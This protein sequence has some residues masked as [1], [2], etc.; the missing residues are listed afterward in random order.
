VKASNTGSSDRFG[1]AVALSADGST[2]AVAAPGESSSAR[3][4]GGDEADNS[5][6]LAGAVYVFRRDAMGRWAQEAYLKANNTDAGDDFGR[7]LALSADG[8]RL[9]VGAPSEDSNA[10]FVGGDV[11]NNAA[12]DA[13]AAYVFYRRGTGAWVLES[14]LKASNADGGDRFGLAVA[15]T[16]QWIAV[17]APFEDSAARGLNGDQTSNTAPDSGAVYL[18]WDNPEVGWS[19]EAYVKPSVTDAGGVFGVAVTLSSDQSTLAVGANQA[20]LVFPAAGAAYVFRRTGFGAGVWAQEAQV[21]PVV[22]GSGDAFGSAVSLSAD[23]SRLAVGAPRESSRATGIGG[24]A[25]DTGAPVSGAAYVFTR[26]GAPVSWTQE[27]YIKATNTDESDSFGSSVALE[28]DGTVLVVG[29][30]SEASNATGIGGDASN[31]E[32]GGNAGAVYVLR[33]TAGA[34]AHEAYVKASNTAGESYFGGR[35][36]ISADGGTLVCGA[37]G[38]SS[39]ATG[40]GGDES[41]VDF[42]SAGAVYIY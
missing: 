25:L 7:A 30:P 11:T 39:R 14:Y 19:Q 36:A 23:G 10:R 15:V 13:G 40:L 8:V 16:D 4:V 12:V 20:D 26:S 34:W 41:N 38:E 5:A 42:P 1:G 24:D 6:F 32:T 27:A 29:A 31:N 33:R 18:F 28:A 9:V 3:G 2:L 22:S 17:G 35:V 21:R 37:T